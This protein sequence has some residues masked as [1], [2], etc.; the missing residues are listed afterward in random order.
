MNDMATSC[1]CHIRKI[2]TD[3]AAYRFAWQS[4][5][6]SVYNRMV[7]FYPSELSCSATVFLMSQDVFTHSQIIAIFL[8]LF[9][10]F[11]DSVF[12]FSYDDVSLKTICCI[13]DLLRQLHYVKSSRII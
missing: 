1:H 3:S 6:F 9:Q 8:K 10:I 7:A 5:S 4:H 2:D 12:L 11:H 13:L